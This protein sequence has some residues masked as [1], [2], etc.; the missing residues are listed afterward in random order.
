MWD[1]QQA[2]ESGDVEALMRK[3]E[4]LL[5]GVLYDNI[6]D[7]EYRERDAQVALFFIFTLLGQFIQTEVHNNKGRA[8]IIIHTADII[9]IFELKL[10][11]AGTAEDAIA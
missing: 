2:I 8:D 5:A 9:Y 4:A 7:V 10:W 6:N 3:I 11:S 1:F